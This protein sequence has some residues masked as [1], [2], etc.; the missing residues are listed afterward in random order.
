MNFKGKRVAQIGTGASGIQVIQEIGDVT[1][2]LT[3]YQ[4]T[5]NYCLPMNQRTLDPEE[6][7]KN[8]ESGKYEK[9]FADC[10][11]TFSGFTYD[12]EQKNTLDVSKEERDKF[13]HKLLVEEG[14][15]K[16]WLNTYKDMLFDQKA[17]DEAYNFW[18]DTVR[19]RIT[20]PE[21]RELLAPMKPPHP[22]GTKR[23]SLEQRFYE[24]VDQDHVDII[25][26]NVDPILEVTEKGL[27]TSKGEVEVD[28]LIL[29][30]G[31]D[32]VTGSLAQLNIQGKNGGTIADHWKDGTKT[33]MGIAIPDF[34]NMF[35]LYGPQA[36]TA[37]A[38][39]PSCTQF[40]AEWIDK[41]LQS[42]AKDGITRFEATKEQEADWV[43]RLNEKWNITLFP[44][45]KSWYQGANIPGKRVEPLN[46]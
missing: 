27:R 41:T 14:G 11:T 20:N 17:N 16:Y 30:T 38:N 35:F 34:P 42:L 15:F 8:K 31:F 4:R 29:A 37:F 1:K 3:I 26:V 44:L 43:K 25:D 12:F 10:R 7:K 22:W 18:R 9:A 19:K 21:K 2:H 23:P 40:Q 24:V 6:E 28:I 36:P 39:G 46:W 5:P 33:S 32:S 13:F 45:A